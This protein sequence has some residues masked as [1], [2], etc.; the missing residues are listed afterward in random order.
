MKVFLAA[1][2]VALGAIALAD[3]QALHERGAASGIKAAQGISYT[4]WVTGLAGPRGLVVNPYGGLWV[5]E[6]RS[7][8]I[9]KVGKDGKV[10]RIGGTFQN[11]HDLDM[12]AKGNLYVAE[13][14][15]GRVMTI[16]PAGVVKIYAEYLDGPVDLA[17]SP[18]GELLVCEYYGK[19]L[20][21]LKSPTDRRVVVQGFTPHGLAF[22]KSGAT[23]VNDWSGDRVVEVLP[24]GGVKVIATGVEQPVGVT[25]GRSG[26]IYVP[27]PK[28]GKLI[29]ILPDG[30]RTVLLEGLK[31][32]RDPVFDSQGDLFLAET[33]GD[34][35]LKISGDF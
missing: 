31:G 12:D 32:P 7:G 24:G 28:A 8:R 18:T 9:A 14:N 23:I 21:A 22:R 30:G 11:P 2:F 13:T 5:A 29:R 34:R 6:Q 1:L 3:Q 10:T 27:E 20:V 35:I 26:D 4:V 25:I 33:E 16:S 17:F 19:K 15:T